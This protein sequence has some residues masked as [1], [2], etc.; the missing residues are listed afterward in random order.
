MPDPEESHFLAVRGFP[1]NVGR[2]REELKAK[3]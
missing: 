2:A 3:S 1:I